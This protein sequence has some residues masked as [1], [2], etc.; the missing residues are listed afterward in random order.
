MARKSETPITHG[1]WPGD[2]LTSSWGYSMVLV[3][4]YKVTKVTPH[5]I[6]MVQIDSKDA[7]QTGYLSGT[8]MPDPD[9]VVT[10]RKWHYDIETRDE[11][12]RPLP[13]TGYTDVPVVFTRK[14]NP[15]GYGV[16]RDLNGHGSCHKWDGK[17]QSFDHCD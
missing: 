11:A 1:I 7:V 13:A 17:P 9:K 10:R 5:T 4:W 2:I 15:N 12:G 3:D 16:C 6:T 8:V 14:V